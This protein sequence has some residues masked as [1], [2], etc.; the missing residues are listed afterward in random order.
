V[1]NIDLEHLIWI[2]DPALSASPSKNP[3]TYR[4]FHGHLHLL[5]LLQWK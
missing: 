4:A 1:N 5:H 2:Q 3:R